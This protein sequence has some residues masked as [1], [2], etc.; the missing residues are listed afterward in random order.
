MQ[1]AKTKQ[2]ESF[3]LTGW[4]SLSSARNC[5]DATYINTE[6]KASFVHVT[7]LSPISLPLC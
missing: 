4:T 7:H 6:R 1:S 2:Q 5:K 3:V